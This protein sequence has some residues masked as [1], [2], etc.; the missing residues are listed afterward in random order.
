[1]STPLPIWIDALIRVTYGTELIEAAYPGCETVEQVGVYEQ[2]LIDRNG[3]YLFAMMGSSDATTEVVSLAALDATQQ[4]SPT[5]THP[6]L[7]ALDRVR[8]LHSKTHHSA[9]DAVYD[10]NPICDH[11]GHAWPCETIRALGPAL[12]EQA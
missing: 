6:A 4:D 3:D 11:D 9:G 2:D 12:Q 1:M 7:A 8:A 5:G 10:Q